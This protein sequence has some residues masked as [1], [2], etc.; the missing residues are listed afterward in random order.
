MRRAGV[1]HPAARARGMY[2][3]LGQGLLELFWLAGASEPARD[4]VVELD[5]EAAA[6]LSAALARGP[7]LL[8][9]SHTGNWELAAFAA[10]R[11]LRPRGRSLV[12]VAKALH[13]GAFHVFC[14]RLRE[15]FGVRL[16]AP[17]GALTN[18]KRALRAGDVVVM[19][20]DQVPDR[21]RHGHRIEFLGAKA[22]ADRAPAALALAEGATM[23]VVAADRGEGRQRI[24]VLAEIPPPARK[25]RAGFVER[26]T[27]RASAALD[28][29]VRQSPESWLWLHRRWRAPLE[30]DRPETLSGPRKLVTTAHPG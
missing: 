5:A 25:D 12:V 21:E 11:W 17:L 23:L 6:I 28:G 15:S 19:P 27:E 1:A 30:A 22:L 3:Q 10:A 7:V 24:R 20:I 2:R 9:A 4:S 16:V 18:T 14:T 13:V 26:A 29:F 8:A